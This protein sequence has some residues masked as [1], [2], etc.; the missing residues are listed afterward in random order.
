VSW[1]LEDKNKMISM[2]SNNKI[3]ILSNLDENAFKKNF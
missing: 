1:D 3:G 2:I